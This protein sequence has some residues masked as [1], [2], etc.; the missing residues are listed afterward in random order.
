LAACRVGLMTLLE[1]VARDRLV[2]ILAGAA[3]QGR[4]VRVAVDAVNVGSGRFGQLR[5]GEVVGDLRPDRVARVELVAQP[6]ES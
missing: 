4:I 2:E 3:L 5:A 6:V 1:H